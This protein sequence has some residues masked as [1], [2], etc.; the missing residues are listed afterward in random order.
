MV[1]YELL[2]KQAIELA[3]GCEW[4]ITLCANIS[5][6]LYESLDDVNWVGFYFLRDG[7][8]FLGPF[9]G[10]TACMK[11]DVG[12]GVCGT[13]VKESRIICVDD[14]H[15]FKGHIACDSASEAEIV[16]PI[17]YDDRI[18]GVL[19]IDSPKKFRFSKDDEAGLLQIV[20]VI[21]DRLG[22]IGKY[23]EKK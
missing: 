22:F 1:D 2:K 8:L 5:A 21:E 23:D 12:K 13:S 16:F 6:L 7:A 19:D 17:H 20:Q 11:I 3:G 14:V 18:I 10:K 9:Q 15:L 4:Y